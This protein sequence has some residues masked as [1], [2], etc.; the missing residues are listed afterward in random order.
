MEVAMVRH[1]EVIRDEIQ[2]L[3]TEFLK[4]MGK[5]DERFILLL[6]IDKVFSVMEL[7]AV[8][9]SVQSK[10]AMEETMSAGTAMSAPTS[11]DTMQV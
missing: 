7:E 3:N 6:E 4:G 10:Q 2:Q 5:K 9:D 1:A 8:S 11:E